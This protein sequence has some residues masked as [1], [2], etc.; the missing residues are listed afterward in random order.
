MLS[1]VEIWEELGKGIVICPFKPNNEN[2]KK[3][4][5]KWRSNIDGAS[6]YVTASNFGWHFPKSGL[7]KSGKELSLQD[8]PNMLGK[9]QLIIPA[10]EWAVICT[11]EIIYLKN[12]L[13][14]VCHAKISLS[15]RGL[16]HIG[17]ILKPG[18]GSRLLLLFF[19]H[20][21]QPFLVDV[22]S[23]IAVVTFD[24]VGIKFKPTVED[25]T[26]TSRIKMMKE[27]GYNIDILERGF[28]DKISY[29]RPF[30][31]E[32]AEEKMNKDIDE[33]IKQVT[34]NK[35]DYWYTYYYKRRKTISLLKNKKV[36]GK[37]FAGTLS[38]A[39][40]SLSFFEPF[41]QYSEAMR[42]FGTSILIVLT[43]LFLN[44]SGKDK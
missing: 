13:S 10:N 29:L 34:S 12:W 11:E 4:D 24:R 40:I 3:I 5:D 27:M 14:G 35:S 23:Q 44:S 31:W 42:L 19:N 6:I 9:K 36:I 26:E 16:S 21:S 33:H 28:S 22:G 1:D 17:G 37:I 20:T 18:S 39:G 2:E 25:D 7:E 15:L 41:A 43:T 32:V 8:K 30:K 38:V